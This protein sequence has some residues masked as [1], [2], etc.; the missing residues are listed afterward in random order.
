[1]FVSCTM[2]SDLNVICLGSTLLPESR[3]QMYAASVSFPVADMVSGI[4]YLFLITNTLF[5]LMTG[6]TV[7]G[8]GCN[9]RP[10]KHPCSKLT[11]S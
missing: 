11:E 7:P 6:E 2:D 1:M 8:D 9:A 10:G 3:N 5:R 4:C